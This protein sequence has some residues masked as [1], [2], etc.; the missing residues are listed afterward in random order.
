MFLILIAQ[1]EGQ[2]GSVQSV[3]VTNTVKDTF[4]EAERERNCGTK[5][6]TK[7]QPNFIRDKWWSKKIYEPFPHKVLIIVKMCICSHII[8]KSVDMVYFIFLYLLYT[9]A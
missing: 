8:F 7:T 1:L 6:L 9:F 5:H 2:T 4:S 3:L